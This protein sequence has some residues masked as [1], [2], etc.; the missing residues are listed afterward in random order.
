MA[1]ACF[2]SSAAL[3]AAAFPVTR[4]AFALA[5]GA[6]RHFLLLCRRGGLL[7]GDEAIPND[8]GDLV[9]RLGVVELVVLL[10]EVRP[11]SRAAA[12]RSVRGRERRQRPPNAALDRRHHVLLRGV[13]VVPLTHLADRV[14][15]T[16][17]EQLAP[18]PAPKKDDVRP[19]ARVRAIVVRGARP[20][21]READ[22][23][24]LRVPQHPP[25]SLR[26]RPLSEHLHQVLKV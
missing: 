16:L 9:V 21:A 8:P 11:R 17:D 7:G 19:G 12:L 5:R 20:L 26:E 2:A 10:G 18:G 6:L 15:P 24:D 4:A 23:V 25:R 14:R 3:A 1:A 13:V 22:P